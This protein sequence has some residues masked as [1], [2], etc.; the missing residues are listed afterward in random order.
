MTSKAESKIIS[1]IDLI[2][3]DWAKRLAPEFEKSYFKDLNAFV[4][5]AYKSKTVFPPKDNIFEALQITPFNKVK[6]VVLG[7][8]PYHGEGQAH[9]LAFSVLPGVKVPPSLRNIYKELQTDLGIIPKEHGNLETWAKQGVLLLNTVLTVEEGQ[10]ASHRKKGWEQ[11]TDAIIELL[12]QEKED[13]VFIL[14]GNDAKKKGKIIDRNRHHVLES[15]HPSPLS[16]RHFKGCKHFSKTN[17]LL[18]E[19][20]EW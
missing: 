16:F 11:F 12:N 14:W 6:V 9:G 17:G 15:G 19:P 10:A 7:Q 1:M 2:P 3:K 8:D 20:V 4:D 5:R 13:L 18:K